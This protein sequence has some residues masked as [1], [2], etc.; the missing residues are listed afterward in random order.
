M[1]SCVECPRSFLFVYGDPGLGGNN[2]GEGLKASAK[3]HRKEIEAN[4]YPY[5]VPEFRQ[6]ID[7]SFLLHVNSAAMLAIHLSAHKRKLHYIAIFSHMGAGFSGASAYGNGAE[8]DYFLHLTRTGLIFLGDA[9]APDTNLGTVYA[10]SISGRT[11]AGKAYL[12]TGNN[13]RAA[14]AEILNGMTKN[15]TAISTLPTGVFYDHPKSQI[16][17]LGC[18]GAVGNDGNSQQWSIAEG[19]AKHFGIPVFGF[20][21]DGGSMMTDDKTL[22]QGK[23]SANRADQT[24]TNFRATHDLW[25][26]PFVG[27][28]TYKGF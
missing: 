18:Y 21:N 9:D 28:M 4:E 1:T 26:V 16:R 25:F 20:T 11:D 2:L 13:Q 12:A 19:L 22:G 7:K 14:N 27:K 6:G 15:N 23:R 3:T 5:D 24:R 8:K 17:L 10:A